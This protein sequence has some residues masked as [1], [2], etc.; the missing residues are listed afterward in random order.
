MNPNTKGGTMKLPFD[1]ELRAALDAAR[2]PRRMTI[3]GYV[4]EVVMRDLVA[5]GLLKGRAR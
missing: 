3:T 4:R 1:G 5:Q 2:K